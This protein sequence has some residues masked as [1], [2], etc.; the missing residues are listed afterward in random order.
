MA[1]WTQEKGWQSYSLPTN[2]RQDYSG[3]D[4]AASFPHTTADAYAST[5]SYKDAAS[6]ANDFPYKDATSYAKDFP[7]NKETTKT[8]W[9]RTTN[10]LTGTTDIRWTEPSAKDK[11]KGWSSKT[12]SFDDEK[13]GSKFSFFSK[14][15]EDEQ[16]SIRKERDNLINADKENTTDL[17]RRQ[18]AADAYN[19]T[20]TTNRSTTANAYNQT[21]K[22]NRDTAA[23]KY[24]NSQNKLRQDLA[25]QYN[26]TN[27]DFNTK[28]SAINTWSSATKT[29]LASAQKGSYA[30][31]LSSL[32]T[33]TLNNLVDKGL[34]TQE[35]T[36]RYLQTAADTFQSYYD[37]NKITKFDPKI[38]GDST[39][40]PPAGGLA[41]FDPTIYAQT[42]EGKEDLTRW[43]QA[44]NVA[45]IAGRTYP[46]LDIVGTYGQDTWLQWN[47]A[48][49]RGKKTTDGKWIVAS[50]TQKAKAAEDYKEEAVT[51]AQYQQY[52]DKVM[53]LSSFTSLKEWEAA[54]DPE[55]LRK[56][57]TSL[58]PEDAEDR[59]AGYLPI[60]TQKDIPEAI[61]DQV[62]TDKGPTILEGKLSSVLGPKEEEAASK[63]KSLTID[64][65]NETLK[66]YKKQRKKE[67]ELD[68][69]SGMPGFNEVFNM[70]QELANSLLGDTGVGGLL[71]LGGQNQE[72]TKDS[73]EKQ[74][75]A[76]TGI[77]S[78]SNT[79]YN[80]QKWFDETLTK[81]YEEGAA[82]T[83]W[84][85]ASKQHAI[86]KDF[87]ES[88]VK[89]Y[90][91]PRFNTSRSMS[92]FMSYIDVAEGEENIFQ[93]QSALSALKT[94]ADIRAEAWLKSID[95][96]ND[97]SF[98]AAF[99][100]DPQ[101]G[102]VPTE[103][104]Q[105]QKEAVQ[106]AWDLV[107]TPEGREQKV[108][109]QDYTW[110]Q[111]AYYYGYDLTDKAQF[112]K[113]HYQ[114]YGVNQGFDPAKDA[115]SL[116]DAQAYI[117]QNILPIVEEQK[118]N[119]GNIS[120]LNFVT[121][122]EYA[123]KMLEGV[124]PVKNK[125]AWEKVLESMGLS[126]K[127]MGV[128][129]LK[130]YIEEAFQ[131]G[132]ATKIR[133]G[134]KYLN[135]KKESVTQEKLGID[136]I[137]RAEDTAP[138]ADPTETKLYSAFKDAGFEG[139]ENDFYK[140]FMP[141]VNR[142]DMEFLTQASKGFKEGTALS[143]LS[144]SDPFEALG[145][146]EGLFADEDT[147]NEASSKTSSSTGKKSYFNLYEDDDDDDTTTSKSNAG[148]SFLGSFSSAFKNLT[149]KY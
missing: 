46:D 101:G 95:K 20:Q 103:K 29:K 88:Y 26:T 22:T 148:Q 100:F 112:A 38:S 117:D 129:E 9:T 105:A 8:F 119:M 44:Q 131:T 19:Q 62:K 142:Q 110:D 16:K 72:T 33:D 61:R 53:G 58:S 25:N 43:Q 143:S 31:T 80:W 144:S 99:Y 93:T 77:P 87:A 118:L 126:G 27:S 139:T 86:D 146:I 137:Q 41:G 11:N 45:T 133:E 30:K 52:R 66:E 48:V 14:L 149:P 5:Y 92:E 68:L 36:N 127:E 71:S 13:L 104:H 57:I 96:M 128:E 125:P 136:Y 138:K 15:S 141:D 4:F 35:E 24:N 145:S 89:Q 140:E 132:E 51:D 3:G 23:N 120:F 67:Q 74:L 135:E 40:D 17:Q 28:N 113:L 98:D 109:G 37:T 12:L 47:Y 124:D 102:D 21:Q 6:Y 54:Q 123:D 97:S 108:P 130:S 7:A 59:T 55:F 106:Q 122:S 2:A 18:T 42:N 69:Y 39:Y 134:I 81:R 70:N 114:T 147:S 65:F 107:S 1:Y 85:D 111:L 56:W 50:Q 82:F 10:L 63:F 78:R 121:P 84:E 32:D 94:Q 60:P 83:D 79:V 64:T 115:L 76:V 75:S 34:M 116:S 49:K 90:L 91:N 73:L